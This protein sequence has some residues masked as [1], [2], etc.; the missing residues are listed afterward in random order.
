MELNEIF[1]I[2]QY[3]EAIK[4]ANEHGYTIEEIKDSNPRKF[5]IVEVIISEN[6]LKLHRIEELKKNLLDTDYQ[7]IKYAEGLITEE[8]Y[9]KMKTTRQKWR[10]EINFLESGQ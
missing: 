8:E 7:A 4:F 1:E 6:E 2:E 5:Q 10:D 9:T 3:N